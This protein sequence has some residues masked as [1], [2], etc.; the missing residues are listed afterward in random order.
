MIYIHNGYDSI[1]KGDF[2]ATEK[3]NFGHKLFIYVITRILSELL[4]YNLIL[5]EKSYIGK[6]N[7]NTGQFEKTLFP[8]SSVT[9]KKYH[10]DSDDNVVN[11]YDHTFLHC[12]IDELIKNINNQKVYSWGN[13]SNYDYIKPYK[14]MVKNFLKP[15][16]LPKRTGLNDVVLMIRK[17]RRVHNYCL[18]DSYYIKILE[19]NNFDNVYISIDDESRHFSLLNKLTKYNPI[20]IEGDII[21]T[22]KIVTSFNNIICSQGQFSFWAAWLSEAEKIYWPITNIGP[23]ANNEQN[24]RLLNLTVDDED[25]YIHIKINDIYSE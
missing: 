5:P 8:F 15:I 9:N 6:V 2:F 13:Y 21:E 16:T 22:F 19:E 25:R 20:I 24:G 14:D 11:L 3:K 12:T 18:P 10:F 1:D 7:K 23:N 17:S 4:D